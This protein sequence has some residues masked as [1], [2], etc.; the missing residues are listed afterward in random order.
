MIGV[1]VDV[2]EG[3]FETVE[4]KA[5]VGGAVTVEAEWPGVAVVMIVEE[6]DFVATSPDFDGEPFEELT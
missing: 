6:A 3:A 4:V 5:D 2:E 1:L